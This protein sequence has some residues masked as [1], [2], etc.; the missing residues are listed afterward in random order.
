MK[1]S[2]LVSLILIVL[3]VLFCIFKTQFIVWLISSIGLAMLIYGIYL[4]IKTKEN[5]YIL[6]IVLGTV[7]FIC[8]GLFLTLA[9]ILVGIILTLYGVFEFC[10]LPIIYNEIEKRLIK[11]ICLGLS[12]VIKM[13]IGL[14]LIVNTFSASNGICIFIGVVL[15]A[16]GIFN[17]YHKPNSEVIVL[18]TERYEE[19]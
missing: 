1:R 14:L 5:S 2:V 11:R 10:N 18:K 7:V 8:A 6:V 13:A 19:K 4:T 9:T 16:E 17:L 3:G 15:I 12:A